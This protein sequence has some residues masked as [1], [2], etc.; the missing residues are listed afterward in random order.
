MG[1]KSFQTSA[2]KSFPESPSS[3]PRYRIMAFATIGGPAKVLDTISY[4]V[5]RI[6]GLIILNNASRLLVDNLSYFSLVKLDTVCYAF[7]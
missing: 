5:T 1:H 6:I 2:D 4:L 7:L 3:E